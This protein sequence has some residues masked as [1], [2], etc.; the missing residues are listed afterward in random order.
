MPASDCIKKIYLIMV[1][2]VYFI[3]VFFMRVDFE[4]ALIKEG[5]KDI[6]FWF[7]HNPNKD[8]D[9]A[10]RIK[11]MKY[12]NAIIELHQSKGARR[13]FNMNHEIPGRL[14]QPA[15]HLKPAV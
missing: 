1:L 12:Y 5:R 15:R 6:D 4:R 10:L 13:R 14:H 8:R 9:E 11:T 2:I 7:D 3:V